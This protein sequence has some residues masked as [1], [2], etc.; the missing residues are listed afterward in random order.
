MKNKAFT[1]NVFFFHYQQIDTKK[2]KITLQV[3]RIS[4]Q[5]LF[6]EMFKKFCNFC[7]FILLSR[8]MDFSLTTTK[9]EQK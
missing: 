1:Q 3:L 5:K 8:K 4:L 9:K 2:S 7:F 6:E